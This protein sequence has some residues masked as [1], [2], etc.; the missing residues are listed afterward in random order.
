MDDL[1]RRCAVTTAEGA[2]AEPKVQRRARHDGEIALSEGPRAGLGHR[3]RMPGRED[4]AAHAVGDHG[5]AELLDKRT[6]R[7]LRTVEPHVGAQ[8]EHRTG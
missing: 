8:H 1:G 5:N 6:S 4:A 3:Q 2:V 7:V